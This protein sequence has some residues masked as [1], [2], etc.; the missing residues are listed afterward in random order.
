MSSPETLPV[1]K[2]VASHPSQGEFVEI[3]VADFDPEKHVAFDTV[4][5]ADKKPAKAAK[6]EPLDIPP[7]APV[8]DVKITK[9]A[10]QLANDAGIDVSKIVGTGKDGKILV[11]DVEAAI[12]ALNETGE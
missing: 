4:G 5:K 7:P 1:M 12:D 3:N 2:I 10:E 6:V 8:V 9:D 11:G